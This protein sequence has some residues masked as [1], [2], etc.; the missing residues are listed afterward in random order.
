M[1]FAE[2][3]SGQAVMLTTTEAGRLVGRT[4]TAIRHAVLQ[5][6]LTGVWERDHWLVREDE[7]RAWAA[8]RRPG[9]GSPAPVPRSEDVVGV[10]AEY[11]SATTEEVGRLLGIHPGNARKYLAMLG[12]EGRARRRTDS[13]WELTEKEPL[14]SS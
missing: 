9:R 12:L 8:R 10:L 11:G 1:S 14:K 4:G 6:R 7:V 5:G 2:A 13:Q 3:A